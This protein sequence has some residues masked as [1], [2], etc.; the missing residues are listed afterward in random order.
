M[1]VLTLSECWDKPKPD[2]ISYYKHKRNAVRRGE[3][4]IKGNYPICTYTTHKIET[5]D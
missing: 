2:R 4:F 5:Q 3:E 1:W